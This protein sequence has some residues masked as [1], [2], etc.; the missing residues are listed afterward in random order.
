MSTCELIDTFPSFLNYWKKFHN[1]PLAEQIEGWKN[2]YMSGWPELLRKQ[3]EDYAEQSLDWKQVAREK[4]FPFLDER[5]VAMHAARKNIAS[6][7]KSI[8]S[9]VQKKLQFES[10]VLFVIYVGIGCG[11]GWVTTFQNS[12]AILFGLENIAECGWSDAKSLSGLIAHELGHVAH[13]HWRE[14]QGKLFGSGPWWQL[15]SEGFAQRC[16]TLINGMESWHEANNDPDWL[17][18]CQQHKSW[19]ATEFLQVVDSGKP[20]ASFFGSWHNIQ[21]KSQTGYF[22]GH[23]IIRELESTYRLEEI[24]LLDDFENVAK[25]ILKKV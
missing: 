21:G 20:T 13:I 2:E 24:A 3:V 23:E 22:L 19:L 14:K 1:A 18:W 7:C 25:A 6:Q 5:M 12:L 8:H 17:A 10:D 9:K 15:Y 4:V 11:A 16:E